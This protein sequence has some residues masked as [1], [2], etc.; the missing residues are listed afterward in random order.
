MT[1]P[2]PGSQGQTCTPMTLV[3]RRTWGKNCLTFTIS[4]ENDIYTGCCT[5]SVKSVT[6]L[7]FAINGQ[8]PISFDVVN[9]HSL[10]F[11]FHGLAQV[12]PHPG[13]HHV[14]VLRRFQ[15]YDMKITS[16]GK[17]SLKIHFRGQIR[18]TERFWVKSGSRNTLYS[19]LIQFSAGSLDI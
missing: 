3:R 10:G 4:D 16:Y 1:N 15:L 13:L 2:I 6:P 17:A 18:V 7:I 9:E 8:I 19:N 12:C 11:Y 5:V 14:Q